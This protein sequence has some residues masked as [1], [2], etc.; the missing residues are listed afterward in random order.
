MVIGRG[1]P[2]D[3]GT[4]LVLHIQD[5]T[6][7]LR[8]ISDCTFKTGSYKFQGAVVSFGIPVIHFEI[9]SGKKG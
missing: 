3:Y 7:V 4:L 6:F 9:S 5:L 2:E 1:W 8:I